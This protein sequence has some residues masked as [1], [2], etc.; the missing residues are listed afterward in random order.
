VRVGESTIEIVSHYPKRQEKVGLF[1]VLAERVASFQIQYYLQ[2]PAQ[3]A[4]DLESTNGGIRVRGTRDVLKAATTNGSIELTGVKGA[5]E[6]ESTNGGIE[7]RDAAGSLDAS[8]TNGG[9]YIELTKLDPDG[10]VSA[11]TTNG[12]V[13]VYLPASVRADLKAETTNGKVSVGIPVTSTGTMTS[14][15]VRG[16]MGGGGT[17]ISLATTN[18][19]ID[20]RR[21]EDRAS[22]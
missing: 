16:T 11:E 10:K 7:V 6:T 19:N 8:T 21:L 3:T 13:E 2:V 4:L 22:R 17:D 15:T 20:V 14:K 12:S 1:T 9:I 18:G 5:I